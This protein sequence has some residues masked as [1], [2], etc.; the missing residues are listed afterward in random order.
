[1]LEHFKN[2]LKLEKNH[3]DHTLTAYVRDV[4]AWLELCKGAGLDPMKSNDAE[5][6]VRLY[7]QEL[8]L[9]KLSPGS[10]NRKMSSL[11]AYYIFLNKV[12]EA[13]FH[14]LERISS[15]KLNKIPK[16]PLSVKEMDAVQQLEEID[17]LKQL[18][19]ETLYQTGMRRSELIHLT[20]QQIDWEKAWIKVKGKGGKE[21]FI[22]LS[23]NLCQLLK[24]YNAQLPDSREWFFQSPR[25]GKL[26]E[27]FVYLATKEYLGLVST[28]KKTGPHMLRHAF[29]THLM[30]NGA[31]INQVKTLL[32]HS[33]LAATQVYTHADIENLKKMVRNHHP[34]DRDDNG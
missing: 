16:V 18:I 32:G 12:G 10:I 14:P 13:S 34:R 4:S 7:L 17:P 6:S 15:L 24:A 20:P 11:R 33:S 29:A 8:N 27:K 1:M 3:S 31:E 26:G 21:R 23:E 5:H 19:I 2:Y 28:G 30:H 22:P 9:K 25:G